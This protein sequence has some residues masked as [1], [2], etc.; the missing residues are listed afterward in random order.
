MAYSGIQSVRLVRF[1]MARVAEDD[2]TRFAVGD[3]VLY[4]KQKHSVSPGPRAREVSPAP[5]GESY[6]YVVEK[7]WIV[8]EVLG[9]GR[10]RLRTRRGKQHLVAASD[11]N[12]RRARWWHRWLYKDR[13]RESL[14]SSEV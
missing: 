11:P 12:L 13:F 10:L 1:R 2:V 5:T 3:W 14:A 4:R 8:Q 7:F 9:D 6:S